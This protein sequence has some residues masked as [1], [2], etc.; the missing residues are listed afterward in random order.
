MIGG[1]ASWSNARLAI[2]ISWKKALLQ[3]EARSEHTT[4][5]TNTI[6]APVP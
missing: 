2:I 1:G 5:A 4:S 6:A 3:A